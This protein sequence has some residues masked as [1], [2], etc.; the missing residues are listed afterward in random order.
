MPR[1]YNATI[2]ALALNPRRIT[3]TLAAIACVLILL[4]LAGQIFK[5]VFGHDDV[6]GLVLLFYVD[7]EHNIPSFFSAAQLLLAATLLALI[8]ALKA[9]TGGTFRYRWAGLALTF[10]YMSVDEA[11]GIH[12]LLTGPTRTMLGLPDHGI[13]QFAWVIPGAMIAVALGLWFL[14]L[15]LS[16]PPRTRRQ[17]IVAAVL[18]V[19]G[20]L[21][22][23]LLGGLYYRQGAETFGY[24]L[25]STA[26]EGLEMAGIIVFIDALLQYVAGEYREILLRIEGGR[27]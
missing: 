2:T 22:F 5:H 24:S 14:R 27:S 13:F 7:Q 1:I 3:R 18:F 21:G 25:L 17:F 11:V 12:E 4:S 15:L 10:L 20:A 19:G 26:E 16:L 8:A 6:H 9:G 23:E